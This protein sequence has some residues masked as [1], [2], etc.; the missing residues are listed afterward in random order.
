MAKRTA[1]AAQWRESA[2]QHSGGPQPGAS[3]LERQYGE[4]SALAL[5]LW[6]VLAR[7]GAAVGALSN[8]DIARHG[9]T[10]SEFSILEALY[11][12][13]PLLLGELKRKILVSSGGVTYLVDRLTEQGLA[14][15]RDCP[16]DRRARYAALTPRGESL[17][18]SIFP[19]HAQAITRAAA[20]LTEQE[21]RT[22]IRLLRKLGLSASSQ[23]AS[24]EEEE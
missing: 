24:P 3:E 23:A 18:R 10:P 8:A 21:Q 20:G 15:R 13:G 19:E 6:V 9:L 2:K 5:R 11:H 1:A 17:M 12:K 14:E 4:R 16:G 7:A 22:A